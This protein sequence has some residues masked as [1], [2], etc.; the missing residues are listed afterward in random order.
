MKKFFINFLVLTVITSM[1]GCVSSASQKDFQ[2]LTKEWKSKKLYN[3]QITVEY[4]ISERIDENGSR[5]IL[6]EDNA[7]TTKNISMQN[8]ILLLKDISKHKEFT[9][10]KISRKIKTISDTEW[11]VYYYTD[12][13]W[14]I[15]D[16]DRVAIMTFVE[17][18]GEKTTVFNFTCAPSEY[19]K[20][21]VNRSTY[22][23]LTYSFKD[24][25]ND[26]I[27]INISGKSTPPVD[28]PLWLIKSAFPK[29]PAIHLHKLVKLIEETY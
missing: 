10:N 29:A 6:I 16:S 13:P 27:E 19:E 21:T 23:D 7:T 1:S 5:V 9:G 20:G 11:V 28:V 14:P 24:L 4:C 12:N 25:G 15:A 8:C 2:T 22:F 3:G 18:T 17:N 26:K